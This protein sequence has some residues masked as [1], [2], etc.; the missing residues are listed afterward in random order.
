MG[1]R[2]PKRKSLIEAFEKH[3]MPVTESGCWLWIGRLYSNGYGQFHPP[4]TPVTT[5]YAHRIS[6][7]IFKGE[8]PKD[9]CVLHKCD[10]RCCVNPNHLFLGSIQDNQNDMVKK[11]RQTYGEKNPMS[12]LGEKEVVAIRNDT[13]RQQE[14]ANFYKVSQTTISEIKHKKIWTYI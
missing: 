13:R 11:K 6:Y 4:G 12:K 1:Q 9:K 7:Q 3:F 10:I 5:R 2:G 8:I 14:I